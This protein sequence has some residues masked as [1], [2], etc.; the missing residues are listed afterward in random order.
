MKCTFG[1]IFCRTCYSAV[2]TICPNHNGHKPEEISELRPLVDK[3]IKTCVRNHEEIETGFTCVDCEYNLCAEHAGGFDRQPLHCQNGH[4]LTVGTNL[5]YRTCADCKSPE[6][7]RGC[8]CICHFTVC[9]NCE[10]LRHQPGKCPNGHATTWG[11]FDSER[12]CF[13]CYKRAR[14]GLTCDSGY[15]LCEYCSKALKEKQGP[16]V[17]VEEAKAVAQNAA[18]AANVD[19][20]AFALA[21]APPPAPPPAPSSAHAHVH[22]MSTLGFEHGHAA[23]QQQNANAD[24]NN[25]GGGAVP[26]TRKDDGVEAMCKS[27]VYKDQAGIAQLS[28]DHAGPVK[29]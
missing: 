20:A 21:S 28:D 10:E 29:S 25:N 16:E 13:R 8:E 14:G 9:L 4:T 5:R 18:P 1:C 24:E 3:K 6:L 7:V 27:I 15:V 17:A 19:A 11:N 12:I 26:T 23:G 22:A 2:H